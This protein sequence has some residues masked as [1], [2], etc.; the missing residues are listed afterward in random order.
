MGCRAGVAGRQVQSGKFLVVGEIMITLQTMESSILSFIVLLVMYVHAYS[1][2]DEAF[3]EYRLFMALI[4]TNMALIIIDIL[5]WIFNGLPGVFNLLCNQGFNLLLYITEPVGPMLWILYTHYQVFADD[6]P[7]KQQ[8]NLLLVLLAVNAALAVISLET[9]WFFYVDGSNLYHRGDFFW[10]HTAFCY[11]L[12]LYALLFII[13][14]RGCLEKRYY[15]SLLL[16]YLPQSIG[17][18]IQ[19]FHYGVSFNW[20][21]MMLSLLIIYFN[22]QDH[23]LQIDYLTGVY[24]RR[25][26]DK[27]IRAK[28]QTCTPEASFAAILIDLDQFKLINDRFGHKV[29]DEAL[30]NAI[31]VL[32]QCVRADDFIARYGGDEF[33]I[34]TDTAERQGLAQVIAKIEEGFALFN[35]VSRKP[36]QIQVSMGYDVYDCRARLK[37][38][39]FFRHIDQ[40]MY[41]HKRRRQAG[42][43][44]EVGGERHA[45]G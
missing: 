36:Y 21:G 10:A 2:L 33:F 39:A 20:S 26:L 14:H 9:G 4:Q 41:E 5:G 31:S 28:I 16:Y 1:R 44:Q 18:T 45:P 13:R 25:Q 29:G 8:R 35:Q 17:T 42:Q 6:R 19:V 7:I 15:Y 12:L 40:L 32:R 22:I 3:T 27:Y 30:Q 37:E 43:G 34:I 23:R 38:D 11:G 24:N